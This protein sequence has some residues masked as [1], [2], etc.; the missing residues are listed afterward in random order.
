MVYGIFINTEN[1][2]MKGAIFVVS[3]FK[4]LC[5]AYFL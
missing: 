4:R 1:V 3:N 5:V 2:V